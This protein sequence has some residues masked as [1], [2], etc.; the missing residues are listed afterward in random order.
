MRG[1]GGVRQPCDSRLGREKYWLIVPGIPLVVPKI[2]AHRG[3]CVATRL[4]CA[5]MPLSMYIEL[6]TPMDCVYTG[7]TVP[8]T[9][10]APLADVS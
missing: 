1:G 2:S 3:E 7:D 6:V 8:E 9:I 5:G 10:K 4:T